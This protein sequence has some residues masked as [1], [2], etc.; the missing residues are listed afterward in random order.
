MATSTIS[1]SEGS[2]TLFLFSSY[3]ISPGSKRPGEDEDGE[4]SRPDPKEPAV[5]QVPPP[6]TW[7][8][9]GGKEAPLDGSCHVCQVLW[10]RCLLSS[11]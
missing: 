9:S 4:R 1:E 11:L 5:S 2:V 8:H 7:G 3:C 10:E 6:T